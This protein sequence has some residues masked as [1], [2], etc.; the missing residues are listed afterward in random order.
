MLFLLIYISVNANCWIPARQN[1][2]KV[3]GKEKMMV[4]GKDKSNK[5]E[6][7][8]NE[9]CSNDKNNGED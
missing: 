2:K 7:P 9:E 4:V 3:Y 8:S 5:E 6:D 1:A